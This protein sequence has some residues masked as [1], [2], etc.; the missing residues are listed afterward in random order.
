[1]NGRE[2]EDAWLRS[3]RFVGYRDA[4]ADASGYERWP[5]FAAAIPPELAAELDAAQRK[6][7]GVNA[8]KTNATRA[9]LVRAGL[10]LYLNAVDPPDGEPVETTAIDLP[11]SR[12]RESAPARTSG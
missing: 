11:P 9:N 4:D 2:R 10:R 8:S 3:R 1:M 6:S 7:L 12:A 5:T